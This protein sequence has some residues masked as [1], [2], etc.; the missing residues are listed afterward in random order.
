LSAE[1]EPVAGERAALRTSTLVQWGSL[2][3]VVALAVALT[4]LG[5][6][7]ERGPAPENADMVVYT[8]PS[9]ACC[10]AWIDTMRAEGFALAVLERSA[11]E[12]VALKNERGLPTAT[13][14]C[15][16][17]LMGDYVIEGHVPAE[18]IRRLLRERPAA[19]GLAVP[20][21][22][23]GSPGM[24]GRNREGYEVLLVDSAGDTSLFRRVPPPLR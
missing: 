14:G 19:V 13:F 15:H 2:A 6:D 1:R 9:C 20:G 3:A 12:V 23:A 10:H 21:M 5:G 17:G 18:D 7:V 11:A 22:P 16:T 4:R 24:T 8:T